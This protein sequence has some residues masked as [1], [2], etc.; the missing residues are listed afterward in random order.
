MLYNIGQKRYLAPADLSQNDYSMRFYYWDCALDD[1]THE[2]IFPG[3]LFSTAKYIYIDTSVH[4]LK[5]SLVITLP[6]DLL[7]CTFSYYNKRGVKQEQTIISNQTYNP[8]PSASIDF[9]KDVS[10]TLHYKRRSNTDPAGIFIDF[11]FRLTYWNNG[12]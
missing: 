9:S 1:V 3:V 2:M 7:T 4:D 5:S 8:I 10:F 12:S 6:S 11:L